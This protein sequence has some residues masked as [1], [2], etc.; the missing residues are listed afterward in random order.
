MTRRFA[1]RIARKLSSALA[2]TLHD[3]SA[4]LRRRLDK[5]ERVQRGDLRVRPVR[6][7]AHSVDAYD[8]VEHT[9]WIVDT[10]YKRGGAK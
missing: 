9:R 3:E 7:K 1:D 5:I 8:V 2:R 4:Q 10:S 6:V